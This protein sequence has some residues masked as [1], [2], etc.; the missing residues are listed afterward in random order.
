MIMSINPTTRCFPRTTR[1]AFPEDYAVI[2][3]YKRRT[4]YF[5]VVAILSVVGIIVCLLVK[6]M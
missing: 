6:E 1:D 3:H 4:N 5:Y 2:E